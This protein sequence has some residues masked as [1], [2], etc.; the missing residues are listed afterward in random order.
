MEDSAQGTGDSSVA[1][2]AMAWAHSMVI[3]LIGVHMLG[4]LAV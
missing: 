2:S 1:G 4:Y 3:V